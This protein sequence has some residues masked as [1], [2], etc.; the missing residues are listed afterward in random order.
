M[1][2]YII[3]IILIKLLFILPPYEFGQ[4]AYF[5]WQVLNAI[6]SNETS[7]Y[8]FLLPEGA[9]STSITVIAPKY[10][11][12]DEKY[13]ILFQIHNW[14]DSEPVEF[15]FHMNGVE[16]VEP[17]VK[18]EPGGPDSIEI[19]MQIPE[20]AIGQQWIGSVMT[21]SVEY[22]GEN[23]LVHADRQTNIITSQAVSKLN[24]K[25]IVNTVLFVITLIIALFILIYL[26]W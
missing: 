8:V 4:V 3:I 22:K 5:Q 18:F 15:H 13:T 2:V 24:C 14:D 16:G 17:V 11:E 1:I 12:T 21:G 20:D 25:F 6:H 23:Y 7:Q 10:W 19:E 26:W 9:N